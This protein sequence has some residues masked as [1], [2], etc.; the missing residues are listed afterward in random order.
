MRAVDPTTTLL[1]QQEI[2]GEKKEVTTNCLDFPTRDPNQAVFLGSDEGKIYKA[3]I[4]QEPG[5]FDT[6]DAHEAP[7][8]QLTFHPKS[9]TRDIADLYLTASYDWTVKLWHSRVSS[10]RPLFTFEVAKDYVYDVQWSPLHPSLFVMGDGALN[11]GARL[12]AISRFC[13]R[14]RPVLLGPQPGYGRPCAHLPS[15]RCVCARTLA[16]ARPSLTPAAAG[17]RREQE[18]RTRP[19]RALCGRLPRQVGGRGQ[20]PRRRHVRRHARRHGRCAWCCVVCAR[21]SSRPPARSARQC[22]G[23]AGGP[24]TLQREHQEGGQHSVSVGRSLCR[25]ASATA[26]VKTKNSSCAQRAHGS[27]GGVNMRVVM[28]PNDVVKSL[29][30]AVRCVSFCS[31]RQE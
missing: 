13:R 21:H 3:H 12:A 29:K 15:A 9:E 5:I 30:R 20:A 2:K 6:I 11:R 8:T 17:R 1:L 18:R 27:M 16:A 31:E 7:V 25:I 14:R 23:A 10:G 26:R 24:H 22:G 4:F 19:Q 28:R